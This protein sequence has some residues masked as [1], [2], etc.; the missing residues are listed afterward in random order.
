MYYVELHVFTKAT[1]LG[2]EYCRRK[3]YGEKT[4]KMLKTEEFVFSAAIFRRKKKRKRIPRE[5]VVKSCSESFPK[6]EAHVVDR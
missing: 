5:T 6:Y 2:D 1:F 4:R 3:S